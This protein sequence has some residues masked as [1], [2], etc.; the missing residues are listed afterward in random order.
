MS[1]SWDR[2][3]VEEEILPSILIDQKENFITKLQKEIKIDSSISS[4]KKEELLSQENEIAFLASVLRFVVSRPPELKSLPKE[5]PVSNENKLK[6]ALLQKTPEKIAPLDY[7]YKHLCCWDEWIC[8]NTI[9]GTYYFNRYYP[10]YVIKEKIDYSKT[11][12]IFYSQLLTDTEAKYG[13]LLIKIRGTIVEDYPISL[14][15]G[16]RFLT[17]QP[18]LGCLAPNTNKYHYRFFIMKSPEFEVAKFLYNH[19]ISDES[20]SDLRKFMSVIILY[21]SVSERYEFENYVETNNVTFEKLIKKIKKHHNLGYVKGR[22]DTETDF[23]RN[24]IYIGFALN[25]ML[26]NWRKNKFSKNPT[27]EIVSTKNELSGCLDF[28]IKSNT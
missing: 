25:E 20:E 2:K 6:T 14:L 24:M 21:Y 10:E 8:R 5:I 4:F 3:Y 7:I 28:K 1:Q 22:H 17:L 23:L 26:N 18:H 15:D 13:S 27:K 11:G 9:N 16:A 12:T 19:P